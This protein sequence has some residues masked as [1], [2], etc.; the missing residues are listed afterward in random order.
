VRGVVDHGDAERPHHRETA[1]V[2]DEVVVAEGRPPLAERHVP[3]PGGAA[4]GDDLGAVVRGQE[5]PLLHVQRLPRL[6]AATIRSV[7]RERKR[8]LEDVRHLGGDLALLGEV[9]VG[10]D[11]EV[12]PLLHLGED[13]EAFSRPGPR[14]EEPALRWPCRKRP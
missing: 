5:L 3:V 13:R 1:E 10:E 14:K 12:V 11:R 8:D 4:L 2:D 9:D 6:A 7:W